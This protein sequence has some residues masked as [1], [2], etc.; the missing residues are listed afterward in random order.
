MRQI[1]ATVIKDLKGILRS[2]RI[3]ILL[4][5]GLFCS[6]INV[7]SLRYMKEILEAFSTELDIGNIMPNPDFAMLFAGT[8]SELS[9]IGL[10]VMLLVFMTFIGGEQKKKSLTIPFS[11]GL[12]IE[13]YVASKFILYPI[14]AFAFMS[15]FTIIGYLTSILLIGNGIALSSA[16]ASLVT[17]S[18]EVVF[19]VV[20]C[21]FVGLITGRPG[22]GI[23]IVYFIRLFLISILTIGNLNRFSPFALSAYGLMLESISVSEL[24][25][26]IAIT[27]VLIVA[28]IQAAFIIMKKRVIKF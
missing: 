26:T 12:K 16:L 28:L 3:F 10:I 17:V 2:P 21:T 8:L 19:I 13:S 24:W 11:S 27:A 15:I 23:A 7:T 1:S 14:L 9:D 20:L 25:I 18:L 4:A 6:V 22:I 5:A